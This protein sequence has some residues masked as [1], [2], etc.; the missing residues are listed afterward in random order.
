MTSA[1]VAAPVNA[2]GARPVRVLA[3][4][5]LVSVAGSQAAQLALAF[6]VYDRTGSTAWVSAA[7]FATVAVTG[8]LAPIS[9]WLAD[10]QDRRRLMIV[11]EGAGGVAWLSLLF[12]SSPAAMIGCALLATAVNAPFRAASGASVPQLVEPAR[13][14]WANGL[15]SASSSTAL[16]TG[17]LLGGAL[18]GAAGAKAVFGV[19]VATFLLS[20]VAL[21]TLPSLP[22]VRSPKAQAIAAERDTRAGFSTVFRDRVLLRLMVSTSLTFA[23]FGLTLVADLPLVEEL[24][25]GSVAYG[26]LTTLWG[27]GAVLGAAVVSRVIR[28]PRERPA[29]VLGSIAMGVSIGSIT[30]M[31]TL[32]AIILVGALGGIGSGIAFAPWFSLV[33]RRAPDAV[34]GRVLAAGEAA[35]QVAFALGML[36]AG[37]IVA[38]VGPQPAYVVP[39]LLLVAAGLVARR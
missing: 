36:A 19:N 33:Q 1:A 31:P 29:L 22:P 38:A 5:R 15:I 26:L 13:L 27:A 20:A 21:L 9:G 30:V 16:V 12:V 2:A 7:L 4:A 14:T 17:P 10:H 18:V 34:R 25:G 11:A 28:E 3:A 37:P 23:A 6:A 8:L 35:E 39:G 32:W 24:G